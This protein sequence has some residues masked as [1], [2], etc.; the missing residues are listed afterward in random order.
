MEYGSK[1]YNEILTDFRK[2]RSWLN[3]VTVD[4]KGDVNNLSPLVMLR[5]YE[6]E[7]T[8][9]N[10]MALASEMVLNKEVVF[11]RNGKVIHSF[12]YNGGDLGDKFVG[13]PFLL[14]LLL[15]LCYGILIKK[16]TPPSEDSE[17]EETR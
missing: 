17:T 13:A 4:I 7:P 6:S 15:K 1:E 12:I 11:A 9:D 2:G 8:I 10:T 14:D 16:L 5:S 3:D